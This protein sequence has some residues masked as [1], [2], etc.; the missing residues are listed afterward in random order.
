[1]IR[2]GT[3][4]GATIVVVLA[5]QAIAGDPPRRP[6]EEAI[7]ATP[8][9]Y[10][11]E[12]VTFENPAAAGVRLAGT[13]TLPKGNQRFPAILLLTGSGKHDRNAAIGGHE[14]PL[15]LADTFTKQ[16]YA[17]LRY[18]KR[19]VAESTGDYDSANTLD[20]ASDAAAAVA[21][22][23]TRSDIDTAKVGII[24]HSEGATIGAILAAKDSKLAFIVMMA[25]FA[26][27]GDI[28]VAEQ[29]KRFAM[30]NGESKEAATTTY[31][32]NRRLY[33]AIGASKDQSEA[34]ARTREILTS[35]KPEPD[36]NEIDQ[37]MMF[38][39]LPYMRFILSYDPTQP[40]TRVR[41]PVLYVCGS[42]DLILPPDVNLPP[43]RKDLAHDHDVT[44]V[45]LPGLNHMFQHAETGSPTEFAQIEETVAPE[46]VSLMQ[47]WVAKHS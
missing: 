21:Y 10:R 26:L 8:A 12:I 46:V 38:A 14:L 41:V 45:E 16:G 33:E 20:F 32:L 11:A 1:M 17:V 34:E 37:A 42:K 7:T 28:L 22:L 6:Q 18:D 29:N 2:L 36:Q 47:S 3:A 44:V 15:V 25:G 40:L 35:A 24:G 23:R 31:Q 19:G 5:A 43:L 13:L 27:R 4:L 39:R 30:A 9:P